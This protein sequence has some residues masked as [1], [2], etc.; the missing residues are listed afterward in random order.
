MRIMKNTI[1]AARLIFAIRRRLGDKKIELRAAGEWD[2]RLDQMLR[3]WH[4]WHHA[5]DGKRTAPQ[6]VAKLLRFISAAEVEVREILRETNR[7][8]VMSD[9]TTEH[10]RLEIIELHEELIYFIGVLDGLRRSFEEEHEELRHIL[11]TWDSNPETVHSFMQILAE[12]FKRLNTL[13]EIAADGYLYKPD[14]EREAALIARIAALEEQLHAA[15]GLSESGQREAAEL[16]RALA[17]EREEKEQQLKELQRAGA[18]HAQRAAVLSEKVQKHEQALADMTQRLAHLQATP[19]AEHTRPSRRQFLKTI[20]ATAGATSAAAVIGGS[21]LAKS[22]PK[23]FSAIFGEPLPEPKSYK[24][25]PK[26]TGPRITGELPAGVYIKFS[27]TRSLDAA[28]ADA[29]FIQQFLQEATSQVDAVPLVVDTKA[30]SDTR[31]VTITGD[32]F[33][34]HSY[35]QYIVLLSQRFPF[36]PLGGVPG[37]ALDMVNTLRSIGYNKK[38][39]IIG[40][41]KTTFRTLWPPGVAEELRERTKGIAAAYATLR[42]DRKLRRARTHMFKQYYRLA[43][44]AARTFRGCRHNNHWWMRKHVDKWLIMAVMEQ[45]SLYNPEAVSHAAALG[46]MQLTPTTWKAVQKHPQFYLGHLPH[47]ENKAGL[48]QSFKDNWFEPRN[49]IFMGTAYLSYQL[50]RFQGK[51]T[52]ALAAYNAG[53]G[54]VDAAKAG[55]RALPAETQRYIKQVP[56]RIEDIKHRAEREGLTP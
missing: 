45:E 9:A 53:E 26:H 8:D 28:I 5:E 39:Y 4:W 14:A 17:R 33:P 55:K 46:L 32:E 2:E 42:D 22:N 18:L 49:N 54:A 12:V 38:L 44:E 6:E 24:P 36:A 21:L 23:I 13:V 50:H 27:N 51:V 19:P 15:R 37:E 20:L 25:L 34:K 7:E 11:R 47:W 48:I 43:E 31:I 29:Q 35:P 56:E 41:G 16:R 3:G 1:E 10:T 52:D 40:H 30:R